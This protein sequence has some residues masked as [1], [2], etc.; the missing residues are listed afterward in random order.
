MLKATVFNRNK[1]VIKIKLK[2]IGTLFKIHKLY[3]NIKS[4]CVHTPL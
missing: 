4:L 2:A 3:H 1:N